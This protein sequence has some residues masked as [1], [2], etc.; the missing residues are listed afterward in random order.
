MSGQYV[1]QADFDIEFRP[2]TAVVA[3]RDAVVARD[4][5]L[6]IKANQV[7]VTLQNGATPFVLELRPDG[8][9]STATLIVTMMIARRNTPAWTIGKSSCTMARTISRPTPGWRRRSR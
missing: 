2:E 6:A 3:C 7:L 4:Y 9:T 5:A 1:G 8:S